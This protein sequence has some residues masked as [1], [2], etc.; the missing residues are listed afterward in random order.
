VA[1]DTHDV[2]PLHP[3]DPRVPAPGDVAVALLAAAGEGI[4][5]LDAHGIISFVNPAAARMTGFAP[6]ELIGRDAHAMLHDVDGHGGPDAVGSCPLLWSQCDG[7]VHRIHGELFWRKDGTRFP[8]AYVSTPLWD[9]E[10][11]VGSVVVFQ[12]VTMHETAEAKFRGL[13]DAA[14]DAMVIVDRFG[15]ITLVNRQTEA[16]FGYTREELIGRP[17]EVLVPDR[18][19]AAHVQ[20]RADFS[21]RPKTRPMGYGL[22]LFARRKDGSEFSTEISLSPL[23]ADGET[24]I[25]SV[26]RD[27]TERV[28]GAKVLARQAEALREQAQLL[29]LASD[30]IFVRDYAAARITYW[31]RGA[32]ALYGWSRTEAMGSVSEEILQTA[33]PQ[34]IAQIE[35]DLVTNGRWEGQL[36]H[37]RKDGS[38][39]VVASRWALLRT[40]QGEPQAILEVNTDV[41]AQQE[42]DRQKDEFL[43]N[44]S[45]DLRTP[46][47]AIKASIGVILAHEPPATPPP[48]HRLH[49]NIDTAADRMTR[50]VDDLLELT[51]L[52]SGRVQLRLERCDLGALVQRCVQGIESLVHARGQQLEVAAPPRPIWVTVD[53]ERLE[54]AVMNVVGNA[55]KHGWERGHIRVLVEERDDGVCIAV[56]DDGPG[57]PREEQGRIFERF[58]RPDSVSRSRNEGT[59]LGLPIARALVEL[60]GGRLWVESSPGAGSTFFL[61]LPRRP[62]DPA[63]DDTQQDERS[64]P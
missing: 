22:D 55:Q 33:F 49:V 17:V 36:V 5:G 40:E 6:V 50:L 26:I 45:H 15:R 48:I 1:T 28:Q 3:N 34:P 60:H 64:E 53:A 47:A 54:R 21:A 23:E 52:Q 63:E 37:T 27:V 46:L 20:Q 7:G 13:L 41:T 8:V 42:L 11:I 58:Y 14:P 43:S 35:A 18:L 9:R 31:S 56:T 19:R 4:L 24:V 39:V 38:R 30:G 16:L 62:R 51:R 29:E 12:D 57:I 61:V 10:L 32:E 59:G 25:I 2:P 44:V